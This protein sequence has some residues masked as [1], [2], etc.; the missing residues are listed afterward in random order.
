MANETILAQAFSEEINQSAL[1][2]SNHTIGFVSIVLNN[3]LSWMPVSLQSLVIFAGFFILSF[4]IVKILQNFALK[5]TQKT[6]SAL[7]DEIITKTNKPI[8]FLLFLFGVRLAIIPLNIES[9]VDLLT[10]RI[11]ISLL[12][13]VSAYLLIAVFDTIIEASSRKLVQKT[14]V[15]KLFYRFSRIAIMLFFLAAVL[16]RWGIQV[17]PLLAGLGVA[18]IA[19]AFAL[20]ATL[21]NIFGGVSLIIDNAYRIGDIIKLESGETGVVQKIGLRSTK[22]LTWDNEIIVV[23]NGKIA[24][25]KIQN[26]MQ[27]DRKIRGIIDFG[28]VYGS[29]I[30]KVKKVVLDTLNKLDI[31]KDPAPQVLFLEMGDFALKFSARFWVDDVTKRFLT[32]ERANCDIYNALTKAG[33]DIAFPTQTVYLKKAKK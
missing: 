15:I 1:V 33:I 6:K 7:D 29:N 4:G 30:D 26:L 2:S 11:I 12:M 20:Q 9:S 13:M 24:D 10:D 22:I 25:S 21:G 8:G 32:K 3:H 17:G 19:I 23:P 18:G 14:Q 27:P 5:L 16:S 31:M 28:V